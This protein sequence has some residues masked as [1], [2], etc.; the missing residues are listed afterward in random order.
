[1]IKIKANHIWWFIG[2]FLLLILAASMSM[3]KKIRQLI[4]SPVSALNT[5]IEHTIA[6]KTITFVTTNSSNT[7]YVDSNQKPA[8]LEYDLANL[9]VKNLGVDYKIEFIVE[10]AFSDMLS[11]LLNNKATIAAADITVTESRKKNMIFTEPYLDIQQQIAYNRD[12]KLPP[13][14][15]AAL[16]HERITVPAGTSFV[17]RLQELNNTKDANLT[18]DVQE[19][20]SSER[21]LE[22]LA[23]QEIDFT[24]AD[25]HLLSVVQYYYPNIGMG[26][27]IGKPE[28]IAWALPEN[29]DPKLVAQVN[30]FFKKIK[31]DG[32]LANLIDRYHGNTKRLNPFD[33]K[34]F[35]SKSQ[36][37]LP[38]YARLFKGA[39]DA[40]DIDWRLLAAISYQE[41]HWNT[42]NTSPTNVRGLMMLT[43]ETS[44]MMKVSDRLDPKQSIPAGA[45]FFLWIKD[46]FPERIQEP[47]RTFMALASYNIGI[48]HIEDARVLAQRLKLDP[49]R[50]ADVKKAMMLLTEPKYYASAKHGYCGCAQ[51]L[52]YTESIRS[53]YKILERHEPSYD[54][55]EPFKIA[56]SALAPI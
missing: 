26:F 30:Q 48:G 5:Q 13:R 51:P 46:H 29:A 34:T 11:T 36:T 17:D 1:L 31:A 23:N 41:S 24:I 25:N 55:S 54:S 39:Q 18:W 3:P 28:K 47:D 10:N 49:D 52:I 2:I 4:E 22:A 6:K 20:T 45:K 35:L 37:L 43:E 40:T 12:T 56:S 21:L 53:Y 27:T 44:D 15:L 50:W 16:K 14:N 42:F 9:F 32:T 7:Y 19:N 33:V 8:G 38:K